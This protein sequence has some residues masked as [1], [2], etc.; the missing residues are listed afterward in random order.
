VVFNLTVT[1][2]TGDGFVT[3][4][5]DGTTNPG[6]SNLNFAVGQT[7]ANR[8]IVP[9]TDGRVDLYTYSTGGGTQLV[10]DVS[11]YYTN[12]SISSA[13]GSDFNSEAPVRIVDTRPGSGL[14]YSG[15][16]LA[17]GE[18]LT[19]QVAG[20]AG[21]PSMTSSSPPTAVVMNV[22]VTDTTA[23]S[24]LAA[25]P[26]NVSQPVISDINWV[27]GQTQPDLIVVPVSP[28]GQVSFYNY[29][30]SADLVIDVEGYYS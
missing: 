12:G 14:P 7:I 16:T 23:S 26:S 28:T 8:V 9:V 4:Y 3:A 11:G 22:T 6:A 13:S 21:A 29:G 30:G 18:T 17:A 19:I 25:W 5:P 2:T 24:W 10:A 15:D 1:D 20:S 27:A